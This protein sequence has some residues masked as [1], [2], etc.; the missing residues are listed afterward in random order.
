MGD[1]SAEKGKQQRP[2]QY[3]WRPNFV[4]D[5]VTI[6]I[7]N[8]GDTDFI[9]RVAPRRHQYPP[10]SHKSRGPIVVVYL[11]YNVPWLSGAATPS[12]HTQIVVWR[13]QTVPWLRVPGENNFSRF[14]FGFL[15]QFVYG[16]GKKRLRRTIKTIS[17]TN[18]VLDVCYKK[19]QRRDVETWSF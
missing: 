5:I 4:C 11:Y 17:C 9:V 18:A 2:W 12:E 14:N 13:R 19:L 7:Q 15:T 6:M 3:Q 1:K 16:V 10:I 8:S